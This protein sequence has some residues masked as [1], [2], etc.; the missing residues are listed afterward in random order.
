MQQPAQ[1]VFLR[2]H[3]W[4]FAVASA[5]AAVALCLLTLPLHLWMHQRHGAYGMMHGGLGTYP[6]AGHMMMSHP[7]LGLWPL[8]ALILVALWAGIAGAIVAAVYNAIAQRRQ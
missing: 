2:L 1:P 6:G 4:G 5:V 3:V 7:G 8:W